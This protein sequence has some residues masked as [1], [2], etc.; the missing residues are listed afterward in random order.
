[1]FWI[2][3]VAF[4]SKSRHEKQS[5]GRSEHFVSLIIWQQDAPL[6]HRATAYLFAVATE[7]QKEISAHLF[8]SRRARR[9]DMYMFICIPEKKPE[10]HARVD[11]VH[12][13]PFIIIRPLPD[14]ACALCN[15]LCEQVVFHPR[16]DIYAR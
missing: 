10:V 13:H 2:D 15:C 11:A 6:M 9:I 12:L 7:G 3:Y 1:M 5:T 4:L 14:A 8:P 16:K